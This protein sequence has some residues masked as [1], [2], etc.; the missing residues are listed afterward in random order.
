MHVLV[1][2]PPQRLKVSVASVCKDL[3]GRRNP[4]M[5]IGLWRLLVRTLALQEGQHI[6][7]E[8]LST[9]DD[10]DMAGIGIEKELCAFDMLSQV[11]TVFG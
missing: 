10:K 6:A 8:F 5:S 3:S 1:G 9:F 4:S 2:Q 7:V 11:A